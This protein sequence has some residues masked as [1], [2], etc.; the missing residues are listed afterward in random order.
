MDGVSLVEEFLL[1]R[2]ELICG[3]I[4]LQGIVVIILLRDLHKLGFLSFS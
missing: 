1:A 3:L 2:V 4:L